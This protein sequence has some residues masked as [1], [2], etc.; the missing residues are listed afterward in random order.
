MPPTTV[1]PAVNDPKMSLEEYNELVPGMT[2]E[3]VAELVG[4]PG[5]LTSGSGAYGVYEWAGD[6]EMGGTAAVMFLDG[7]SFE[8]KRFD[9]PL[10]PPA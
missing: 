3:E 6:A 7:T 4:G 2:Y 5:Q 1:P 9:R 10:P 8:V